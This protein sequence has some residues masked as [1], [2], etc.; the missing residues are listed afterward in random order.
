[1]EGIA[2]MS[3]S[4]SSEFVIEMV[5]PTSGNKPTDLGNGFA[6]FWTK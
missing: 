6:F 1:M 4:F 3:L 2:Y 5:V